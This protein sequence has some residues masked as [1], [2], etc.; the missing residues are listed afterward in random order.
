M[1]TRKLVIGRVIFV[2]VSLFC[3]GLVTAPTVLALDWKQIEAAANREGML[4]VYSPTRAKDAEELAKAFNREYPKIKVEWVLGRGLLERVKTEIAAR[5]IV[6]DAFQGGTS[7]TVPAVDMG[8]CEMFVPPAL[9]APGVKWN[10]PMNKILV[11]NG[12]AVWRQ[13]SVVSAMWNTKVVPENIRPRSLQDLTAPRYKGLIA[14][15]NPK[16]RGTGIML[17][18]AA[19]EIAPD[20]LGEQWIREFM[21]NAV[22]SSFRKIRAQITTG[23]YG[24]GL[25]MSTGSAAAAA[26]K[27]A[28][29]KFLTFS[30]GLILSPTATWIV[31]GCPHPNAAKVFANWV[32]TKN[33]QQAA[34]RLG[35]GAPLM[36]GVVPPDPNL[37][38]EGKPILYSLTYESTKAQQKTMK[39]AA[40]SGIFD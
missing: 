23:E 6:C 28:P 24:I 25:P 26:R 1:K 36:A 5:R 19:R 7:S 29:V 37:N 4:T 13:V 35:G 18:H 16:S 39:W 32:M 11:K 20:K 3:A 30:E 34:A 10:L 12:L 27:G 8:I 15:D 22:I 17:I 38:I 14:F 2:L 21:K 40:T 31:K 33:G 9:S